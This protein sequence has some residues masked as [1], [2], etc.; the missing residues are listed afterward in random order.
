MRI[1]YGEDRVSG[2]YAVGHTFWITVT[3]DAGVT[4]ATAM[5]ETVPQ[6]S[7]PD[8][9]W[10]QG[11][12]VDGYDW[13]D[14]SL[15]ILPTDQVHFRSDEGY[16]HTLRVGTITGEADPAADTVSGTITA[17]WLPT[18]FPLSGEA[19]AWGFTFES[20]WFNLDPATGAGDY[21]VDFSPY[22]LL[23]GQD[24]SVFYT[25]PPGDRVGNTVRVSGGMIYL[26][27]VTKNQ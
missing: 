21:S 19:G 7:G 10:D 14:P 17:P 6:G 26:P 23:P 16:S 1:Q 11:F 5:A 8:G 4:K 15:D 22:D 25:V 27:L 3:D 9:A 24:I 12:L 13:S 20:F 2:V 18:G